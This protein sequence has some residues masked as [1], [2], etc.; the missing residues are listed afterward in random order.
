MQEEDTESGCYRQG[1][2]CFSPGMQAELHVP[3]SFP[4]LQVPWRPCREVRIAAVRMA[5]LSYAEICELGESMALR[6]SMLCFG[7]GGGIITSLL[8]VACC[9]YNP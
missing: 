9:K 2:P 6:A 5:G 3:V 7:V 4:R 8:K 1:L